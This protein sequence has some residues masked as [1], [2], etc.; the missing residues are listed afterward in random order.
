MSFEEA[1]EAIPEET[2]KEERLLPF[3]IAGEWFALRIE[4]V[5]EIV[6]LGRITRV[7]N[8]HAGVAGIMNLRGKIIVLYDIRVILG[9]EGRPNKRDSHVLI[10]DLGDPELEVGILS[11]EISQIREVSRA[12]LEEAPSLIERD[13]P[14]SSNI[15][16]IAYLNG[17]AINILDLRRTFL[18]LIP[19]L[20][21]SSSVS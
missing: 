17:K 5:K 7:P 18:P 3:R 19:D 6:P 14:W 13:Q 11:E 15:R 21:G 4:E 1:L 16:S 9:L 10:L 20:E 12:S 8:V 2:E